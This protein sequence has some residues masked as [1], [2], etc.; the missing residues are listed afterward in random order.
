M[1]A[2]VARPRHPVTGA[3]IVLSARTKNEL[4]AYVHRVD[5]L[6]TDLRLGLKTAVQVDHELRFMKHGA[7]TLER[8]YHGYLE[9]PELAPNTRRA[10]VSWWRTLAVGIAVEAFASLDG[11]RLRAWVE[12]LARRG[13]AR[14]S[15]GA[16]WRK[17][18]ALGTYACE[19]GWVSAVPWGSWHPPSTLGAAGRPPRDAARTVDELVRLLDAARTLDLG[20]Q[21]NTPGLAAKVFLALLFGLRQGELAGLRW[22]DVEWGPPLL[23]HVVRQW[24]GA[25]LKRGTRPAVLEGLDEARPILALHRLECMHR[26]LFKKTG[27]IFPGPDSE[28]GHPRAYAGGEVLTRRDVRAVVDRASLARGSADGAWSAHSFRSTFVT[29]EASAS[30]GDLRRVQLRSRHASL[31]SLVR[32]LR[33]MTIAAPSTPLM[34]LPRTDSAEGAPFPPRSDVP[35]LPRGGE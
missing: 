10:Y 23:I 31:A 32:Y 30:G 11:P 14:T 24:R 8:V 2:F 34:F 4:A 21:G 5:S 16:A 25:P 17:L 33:A 35:A 15:I 29:L 13:L 22:T 19:R 6:R 1:K 9:R 26:G 20:V 12:Q 27:P 7:V 28:R 18:S 3:R